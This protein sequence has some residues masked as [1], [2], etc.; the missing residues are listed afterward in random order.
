MKTDSMVRGFTL[1]LV[2]CLCMVHGLEL[3]NVMKDSGSSHRED[4][5][6]LIGLFVL[7]IKH[8]FLQ[9]GHFEIRVNFS[10]SLVVLVLFRFMLFSFADLL[11]ICSK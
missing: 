4:S 6:I 5:S 8:K 3:R 11:I 7:R 1:G 10:L 9:V 2:H